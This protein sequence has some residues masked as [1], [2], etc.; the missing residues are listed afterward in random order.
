MSPSDTCRPTVSPSDTCSIR[1]SAHRVFVSSGVDGA[2]SAP[3]PE[4]DGGPVL[5]CPRHLGPPSAGCGDGTLTYPEE[6]RSASTPAAIV[7]VLCQSTAGS[8]IK[9]NSELEKRGHGKEQR[10]SK[11]CF[12]ESVRG[13]LKSNLVFFQTLK[14]TPLPSLS[15]SKQSSNTEIWLWKQTC[16]SRSQF[17]HFPTVWVTMPC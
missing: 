9:E 2:Y 17:C 5:E 16:L 13:D 12:P 6:G 11:R 14:A 8:V 1:G 15:S 4:P 10:F 7:H 3:T